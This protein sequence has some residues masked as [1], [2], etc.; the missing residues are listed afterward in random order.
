MRA[1]EWTIAAAFGDPEAYG[2][3]DLPEWRVR[4]H[5][6]GGIAFLADGEPFI[7]AERPMTV[8]R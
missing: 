3:P 8:R 7:A 5:D 1:T 2:I 4:S 6:C